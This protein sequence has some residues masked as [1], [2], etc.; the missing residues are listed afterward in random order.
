V[1]THDEIL[2]LA[3]EAAIMSVQPYRSGDEAHRAAIMA[4]FANRLAHAVRVLDRALL[5]VCQEHVLDSYTGHEDCTAQ[6]LYIDEA[7][8]SVAQ[9]AA[10]ID[11]E[12]RVNNDHQ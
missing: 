5:L 3:E 10:E 11:V 2:K 9:A 4:T 7:R 12:K 6:D 8:Q 1:I